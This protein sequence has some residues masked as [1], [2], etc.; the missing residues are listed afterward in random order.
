VSEAKLFGNVVLEAAA[1]SSAD[2]FGRAYF[3]FRAP[4]PPD[5]DLLSAVLLGDAFTERI[6]AALHGMVV[7]EEERARR[8][9]YEPFRWIDPQVEAALAG[10][11]PLR[12][13]PVYS[14]ELKEERRERRS[15]RSLWGRGE[16]WQSTLE[17]FLG[18]GE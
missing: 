2:D 7:E 4:R 13:N 17:A 16:G 1:R 12:V 3:V 14:S 18:G 9:C 5:I 6:L 8:E 10:L 11:K 15:R